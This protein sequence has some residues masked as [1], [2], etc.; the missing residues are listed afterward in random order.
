MPLETA[1]TL[2]LI[3]LPFAIFAFVL[4]WVQGQQT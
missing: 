1:V 3:V 4:A 2:F